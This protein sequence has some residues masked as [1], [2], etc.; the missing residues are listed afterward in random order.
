[1]AEAVSYLFSS[2]KQA[3]HAMQISWNA[4]RPMWIT[5]RPIDKP[6]AACSG[7]GFKPI[8]KPITACS[9]SVLDQLKN[10][11]LHVVDQI[12]TN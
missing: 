6:M 2:L 9:G 10:P 1:M 11:W 3:K 8:D 12:Q 7:V 4:K 5:S